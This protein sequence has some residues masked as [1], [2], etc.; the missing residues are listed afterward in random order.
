MKSKAYLALL[1]L[2]F[3][4]GMALAHD[5]PKAADQQDKTDHS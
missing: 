4:A 1:P 5:P 2:A 3:T